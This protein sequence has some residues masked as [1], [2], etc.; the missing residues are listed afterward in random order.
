LG[1][2]Y[3][4]FILCDIALLLRL[5]CADEA[6]ST[7]ERCTK[8]EAASIRAEL[9]RVGM[10]PFVDKYFDPTMAHPLKVFSAFAIEISE[11]DL[12][13][14]MAYRAIGVAMHRELSMRR[15]LSA[16]NT[17][18]DAVELLQKS[19][20]ILVITGAGVSCCHRFNIS[21]CCRFLPA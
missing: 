7:D 1:R 20:N 18:K 21:D 6:E 19:N 12:D 17:F 11:E 4:G 2:E 14:P 16:Y 5:L 10:K 9:R 8:E 3:V 13:D 15:R